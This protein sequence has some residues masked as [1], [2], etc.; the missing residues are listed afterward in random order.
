MNEAET[1]NM[2]EIFELHIYHGIVINVSGREVQTL[3]ES[4]KREQEMI[5]YEHNLWNY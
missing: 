2:K 1:R 4:Q 3:Y 5:D